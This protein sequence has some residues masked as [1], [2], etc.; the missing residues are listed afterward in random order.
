MST[1]RKNI[2]IVD[3]DHFLLDMYSQKFTQKGYVVEP[4]ASVKAALEALRG[5]FPADVLIF[6]IIMPE[7]D[8]FMFLKA[9]NDEHLVKDAVRIALTNQSND[10]EK[11]RAEDLGIDKYIIKASMIPSEVVEAVGQA[12]S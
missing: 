2:L 8:G 9:L 5:G 10:E 6:D 3:D 1:L 11:K 4:C 7:Q 12:T